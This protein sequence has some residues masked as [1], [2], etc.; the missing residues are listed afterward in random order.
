MGMPHNAIAQRC[1]RVHVPGDVYVTVWQVTLLWHICKVNPHSKFVY[2]KY[3][4]EVLRDVCQKL[5]SF[6]LIQERFCN[7]S[8]MLKL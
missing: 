8:H 3:R 4:Q 7:V 2:F 5:Q 1:A 6:K